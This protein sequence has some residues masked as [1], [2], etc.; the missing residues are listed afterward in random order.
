MGTT[1]P[2]WIRA[3]PTSRSGGVLTDAQSRSWRDHGFAFVSGIFELEL[4]ARLR[5]DALA[6]YPAPDSPEAAQISDFGSAGRLVFP[7]PSDAFNAV[8]LHPRLLGAIGQLLAV[9]TTDLRLTQSNLWPKYGQARTP[10]ARDNDEQRIHVDYPN[11]TLVH[12]SPWERPEAVELIIYLDRVEDCAGATALVVREGRDDP[13]Y[14]W[15]IVDSPGIGDLDWI[16]DRTHSLRINGD[17]NQ[18]QA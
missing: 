12:P 5:A 9:P 2:G 11:H 18:S 10:G 1:Q 3:T 17:V 4:L 6:L 14:R 15:P 7:S 16:N 8:T 13:A